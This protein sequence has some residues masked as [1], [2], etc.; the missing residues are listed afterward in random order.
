MRNLRIWPMSP[1]RIGVVFAA[2]ALIVVFVI[3]V[4]LARRVRMNTGFTSGL[5][6]ASSVTGR[7]VSGSDKGMKEARKRVAKAGRSADEIFSRTASGRPVMAG[8]SGE[9]VSGK[10][11]MVVKEKDFEA[12]EEPPKDMFETLQDMG[13]GGKKKKP[14]LHMTDKELTATRIALVSSREDEGRTKRRSGPVPRPGENIPVSA[15]QAVFPTAPVTHKLFRD[16]AVWSAFTAAHRGKYPSVDFKKQSVVILVSLS[17]FP[18]GIFKIVEVVKEKKRT[19]IR[20]RVDPFAISA[21]NPQAAPYLYSA[22]TVDREAPP[23]VLEQV[24]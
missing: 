2:T 3:A 10:N 16:P 17:D 18:S 7:T 9:V 23:I 4:F 15:Y 20:Y 8:V 5:P 22:A 19:R 21:D 24:P 6:C 13:G 1:F 12:V 14:V 11:L